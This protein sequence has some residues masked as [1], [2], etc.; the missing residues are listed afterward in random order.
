VARISKLV[1]LAVTS[2]RS[3]PPFL[4]SSINK[5]ECCLLGCCAVWLLQQPT[6]RGNISLNV[7]RLP[8]SPNVIPGSP[9]LVTLS[10]ETIRSSETPVL[11]RGTL[12]NI[13]K[14]GILQRGYCT[15]CNL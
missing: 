15:F 6:F 10:M 7:L 4:N 11:T 5:D 2:N 14:D 3:T 9:I 13:P 8:I 1:T 12:R